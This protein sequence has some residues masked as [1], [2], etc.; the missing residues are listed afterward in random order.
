MTPAPPHARTSPAGLATGTGP[1]AGP[2][3]GSGG[4]AEPILRVED[5]SVSFPSEAGTVHAVRGVSFDLMPGEV[6]GIVG[7]SGSGKSVTSLAVMGLLPPTASV[8]GR[9][10]LAG[11][12]LL[13]LSDAQMSRHRG[14]TISMVFQDPMSSLTPVLTIGT[15]IADAI[16][17]HH[18]RMPRPERRLRAE[19]LL[20]KVGIPDPRRRLD[21]FPHELSGGMKQRVMIAIAI[22]NDPEVIICD[23]PTTALD[24]TVQ[25]QVLELLALAHEETGA[26]IVMI[27]HDLGVVAGITDRLLVMYAG[28]AVETGTTREVFAAPSMP[29]TMGLIEAVP[30]LDLPAERS[31]AT[32][33]GT[34]PN[35]T[36]VPRGC[37]F[38][39]RCPLA[40]EEC[41][42][43]EPALLPLGEDPARRSA[44]LRVDDLAGTDPQ[45]AYGVAPIGTSALAR[46]PRAERRVVLAASDLRRTFELRSRILRLH[47]GS[48]HA[49]DGVSFDIRE[50]E[51]FTIVG[52]SGSGKTTTL[53][54][55]MEMDP[56]PGVRLE[57][58]G[59]VIEGSR[60]TH[61][62]SAE[63][64]G[65]VQM[66]FQDPVG[67]LS[68]RQTVYEILAEPMQVQGWAPMAIRARILELLELVGLARDH[69]DRFPNA[70]SGGQRQ[71]LGIARALALNPSVIVLDEPVSALDVSIQAG[72]INL[73]RRLKA[74]LGISYLMVA[75][76]LSVV[77][78]ISDRVAV[79]HL[80]RFVEVGDVA[81]IFDRPRHPYTQ[82]L[83][84]A[85]PIPDPEV[86]AGRTH[87]VLE[88]ELPSPTDRPS[89]CSFRT[90]CPL[91]RMLPEDRQQ[92]C[93]HEEPQ[94]MPY[95]DEDQQVACHHPQNL[96]ADAASPGAPASG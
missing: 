83:L 43:E 89:G 60:R 41:T 34:P 71:R 74:E 26:A 14:R 79:M 64:R 91:F 2:A 37:P 16:G 32:I 18:P 96:L 3:G 7:E 54:E 92:A 47:Q 84:S 12:S 85:V 40:A 67:A 11:Q 15:Q 66:V 31:L 4:A 13:G 68:P 25:A 59:Q 17:N 44:C 36:A 88:G 75:H 58:G 6:L 93:L 72:V 87:I 86:E 45:E 65:S 20:A 53:L 46:R 22:A 33:P 51:C 30:R 81:R 19:E 50:A 62:A 90:R 55:V 73:L 9:V 48:V 42:R 95:E 21:A 28:R 78:H 76:D 38:A 63:L 49:V 52:E 94:L 27:T 57:I 1:D 8:S 56:Q 82:A 24:V 61:R 69:V 39:P 10:T 5:L 80:G 77:R 35:L 23:E 29:Y 70:F